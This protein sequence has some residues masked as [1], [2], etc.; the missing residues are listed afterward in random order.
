MTDPNEQRIE[1]TVPDDAT[2][3]EYDRLEQEAIDKKI[4]ADLDEA[5]G[6]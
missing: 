5:L 4:Q 6:F 3:E 1:F 2:P